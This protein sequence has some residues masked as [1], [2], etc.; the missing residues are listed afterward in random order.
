MNEKVNNSSLQFDSQEFPSE[1]IQSWIRSNIISKNTEDKVR[2]SRA[3]S[4]IGN[5]LVLTI[6][7]AQLQGRQRCLA[8]D[9][10]PNTALK[11]W[12]RQVQLKEQQKCLAIDGVPKGI[13]QKSQ[14][15]LEVKNRKKDTD[16]K[17]SNQFNHE[18][19]KSSKF[20]KKVKTQSQ[21]LTERTL[22]KKAKDLQI[23]CGM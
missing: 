16:V 22:F 15:Q 23:K 7:L 10:V 8:T 5:I 17:R 12:P 14:G 19:D 3:D 18:Q 6:L 20:E 13:D 9:G 2:Y 11:G 1:S 4:I 21:R